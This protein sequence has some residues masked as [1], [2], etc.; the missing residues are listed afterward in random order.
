MAISAY[1]N[2]TI[3]CVCTG[4]TGSCKTIVENGIITCV[5]DLD[6]SG[7]CAMT[8]SCGSTQI[9]GGGLLLNANH[10]IYITE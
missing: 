6:C 2:I 10:V 9:S 1:N 7:I 8:I 3:D 5:V 4:E